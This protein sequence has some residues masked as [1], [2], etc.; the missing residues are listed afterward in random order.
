MFG[1]LRNEDARLFR[2]LGRITSDIA[3]STA[4]L[5]QL[6]I[7]PRRESAE[8]ALEG[9]RLAAN[10]AHDRENVDVRVFSGFSM[11]LD[12]TEYRELAIALD[13]AAEAVHEA[14]A[15]V[16]RLDGSDAPHGVRAL[17]HTLSSAASALQRAVPMAGEGRDYLPRGSSDVQRIADAGE[18]IYFDGVAALF[19]G[20]PDVMHILRWKGIYEKL[21]HSLARCGRSAAVLDQLARANA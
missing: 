1:K 5:E 17:A 11:R 13:A 7:E 20:N 4:L 3:H 9:R 2:Q 6:L 12:A 14:I 8:I 19:A 18:T 10:R 21:W 15:H 16:E